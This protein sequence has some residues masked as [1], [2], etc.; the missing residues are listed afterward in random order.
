MRIDNRAAVKKVAA[1]QRTV[2]SGADLRSDEKPAQ[3]SFSGKML[4]LLSF[5]GLGLSLAYFLLSPRVMTA[6]YR[7]LLFHPSPFPPQVDENLPLALGVEPQECY[8]N[9]FGPLASKETI[10]GWWFPHPHIESAPVVLLSHG[11]SGNITIRA[12]LCELIMRSGASVFVYDYRGFGKSTGS[13]TVEGVSQDGI[14]AY[15]F[16]RRSMNVSA[17]HIFL[18]GESLGAAVSTYILSQRPCAGI[19]LQ[20]G[21]SS[22]RHIAGETFA[23]LKAYPHWLFPAPGLDSAGILRQ[24][25]HPP[26]LVI[27]G[28]LD[29]VVPFEHGQRLYESAR[30]RKKMLTLPATSH[31]DLL[32]TAADEISRTLEAFFRKEH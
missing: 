1:K 28:K 6:L 2:S 30:G 12:G 31:S 19:V 23:P 13:P 18:Y 22:L 9:S 29:Q 5:T 16:V 26:L 20:S 32:A 21:F 25:D 4:P 24:E 8:F 7:P 10:H 3:L 27:H 17:D 15:D 11:N 14:A